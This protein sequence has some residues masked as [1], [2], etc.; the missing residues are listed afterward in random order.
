[1]RTVY[2][3]KRYFCGEY[4]DAY[5]YPVFGPAAKG[6]KRIRRKPS[7]EAQK[8]LNQ[9]HREEKLV[10]LLHANFTPADM[11]IHL[12]YRVQPES[13]EAAK[14]ELTNYLRRVRRYMKK[15]GL[16]E[17]KYI[18][19]TERGKRGGR[20]HHHVTIGGGIDRDTLESLWTNGYANS[21]RLQFTEEGLAGLGHYIVKSPVGKKAWT[22]SKNLVD[23][24][25]RTRDGRIS[26]RRARELADNIQDSTQFEALYPGYLLAKAEAFHNDVNGGCYLVA[27][28]YKQDSSFAKK[29]AIRRRN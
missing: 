19:V 1:M 23:P 26:G 9:R 3:E 15:N 14:K 6:G 24:E 27:R 18:A 4:L 17:L 16:G 22:A 5:I 8:K 2:R 25:P 7:T 10:R 28:L 21:R 13:D 12:T 11:E 29:P 20:Y